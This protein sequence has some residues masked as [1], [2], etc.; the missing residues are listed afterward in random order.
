MTASVGSSAGPGREPARRWEVASGSAAVL[1]AGS[2]PTSAA[3]PAL[4]RLF[5]AEFG[6]QISWLLPFALIALVS[7]LWLRRRA[8]RT[9]RALTGYLLWGSWLVVT[10]LVFSLMSGIVHTYYAVVLAPAIAALVGAGTAELWQL[11]SRTWVG[12]VVLGGVIAASAIWAWALL[13][14]TPDFATGLGAVV[15]VVG[16]AT[17]L[18]I[19]L[20]SRLVH[21]RLAIAGMVLAVAALLVG[22]TAYAYDTMGSALSGGDPSAGPTVP[23]SEA[24]G[25]GGRGSFGGVGSPGRPDGQA[26]DGQGGFGGQGTLGFGGPALGDG[27]GPRGAAVGQDVLDYLVAN[28]GGATWIVAVSGSG[29]AAPIQLATGLPVMTMGGFNGGDASPTLAEFQAYVASGQVRYAIVGGDGGGMPG[30]RGNSDVTAWI[31]ANGTPITI[32]GTTIYDLA[33]AG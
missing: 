33:P 32:G 3:T 23:G 24:F 18:L 20:P 22:P 10:G 4:L 21:G 15:L 19:A 26:G 2:A 27:G 8:G 29:S 7:G 28:Q 30:G 12:G 31:T 11:R 6:G 13:A 14:R 5:N 17:G 16:M 1:A 9:D 25:D